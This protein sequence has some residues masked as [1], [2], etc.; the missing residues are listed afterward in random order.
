LETRRNEAE[1]E[2]QARITREEELRDE[3]EALEAPEVRRI[4][5][6]RSQIKMIPA[7]TFLNIQ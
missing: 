3:N 5:A 2:A 7:L 4:D 6:P 1:Q